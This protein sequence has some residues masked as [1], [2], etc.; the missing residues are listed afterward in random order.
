M[1][2]D[3]REWRA[4]SLAAVRTIEPQEPGANGFLAHARSN[5]RGARVCGN[6]SSASWQA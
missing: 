2:A 3:I 5:Y 1:F 4:D 6:G